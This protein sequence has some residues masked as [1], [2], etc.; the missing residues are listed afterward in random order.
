LYF[1][2]IGILRQLSGF[3]GEMNGEIFE[4]YV[5]SEIY[6]WIK[7]NQKEVELFFYR[8][9]SGL[10][11]DLLIKT[12]K[13]FIGIEIKLSAKIGPSDVNSLKA[14][15]DKLKD[16]WIGGICVNRGNKIEK[17]S[18]PNIW[19]VPAYRLLS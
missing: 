16:R 6:K 17:I 13:G 18:E 3:I 1:V 2:D 15:A 19:V 10:E 11:A 5:V 12:P 14:I 4:T 9:R 7:T 8:T